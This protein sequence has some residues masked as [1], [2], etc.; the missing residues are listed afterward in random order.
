MASTFPLEA[1]QHAVD[2][3]DVELPR[4]PRGRS[5]ASLSAEPCCGPA[6]SNASTRREREWA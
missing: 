4:V 2:L 3:S 1:L 6:F 5:N